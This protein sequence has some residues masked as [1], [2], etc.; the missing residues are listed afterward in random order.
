MAV[1]AKVLFE[2]AQGPSQARVGVPPALD[3]LVLRMREEIAVRK[4][5]LGGRPANIPNPDFAS[6]GWRAYVWNN[7]PG[8]GAE[9]LAYRLANGGFEVVLSPVSNLYFDLAWNKN[10][11]EP[12]LDWGATSTSERSGS[13][14]TSHQ[15]PP[16][17]AGAPSAH[18]LHQEGPPDGLGR[19]NV[20]GS[21][22]HLVET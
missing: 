3:R 12:G 7:V 11:E 5:R 9:D 6:R 18:H 13:S 22:Q 19:S 14:P 21:G 17:P 15:R 2:E 4:T 1:L 16:R 8:W 20:L 10:P